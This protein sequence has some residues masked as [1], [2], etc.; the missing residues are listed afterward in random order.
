MNEKFW[1]LKNCDLFERLSSE[2]VSLL[3]SQSRMRTFPAKNVVYL[4]SDSDDAVL[5]LA[6]GRVKLYHITAEGKQ[7]SLA[8]IEAGEMF[9]ELN[10]LEGGQREEFAETMAKSTVI[11]IPGSAIRNLIE[12]NPS[13]AMGVTRLIGLRRRVFERRLK[14]LLFR[15][16]RDRLVAL[17]LE[18]AERYGKLNEGGTLLDIKLSH[19]EL[20]SMIGSTR[21]SVTLSLGELQLDRLITITRR[22]ITIINRATLAE[23]IGRD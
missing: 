16:N 4:P 8:F 6:S 19:Q 5:L 9:G 2:Q 23:S 21:E 18:L 11:L 10:I 22:R 1:Y 12:Q 13:V 3:E 17:L 15:S 7:S 20:A 14:S